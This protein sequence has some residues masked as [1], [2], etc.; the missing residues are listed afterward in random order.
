M[1]AL[2]CTVYEMLT[3]KLLFK[4]SSNNELLKNQIDVM[5]MAELPRK[6]IKKSPYRSEHFDEQFQF[7]ARK[8]DPITNAIYN[9]AI[10]LVN[11]TR[12]LKEEL[13]DYA[14][15]S[16][17]KHIPVFYDL[18]HR[19]LALDPSKRIKPEEAISHPFFSLSL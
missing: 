12:N 14:S 2:A 19:M 4:A 5:G 13:N 3:G 1:W 15:E 8:T 7:L 9:Q 11:P 16:E 6:L 10:T 17:L 18:L